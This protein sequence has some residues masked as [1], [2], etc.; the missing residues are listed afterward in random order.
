MKEKKKGKNG[1]KI[2]KR[3]KLISSFDQVL[4]ERKKNRMVKEKGVK[5]KK[6]NGRK[7]EKKTYPIGNKPM[8][9]YW[10][11]RKKKE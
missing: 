7:R 4:D 11:G 6:K 2:K 1:P 3:H 10:K 8:P 5:V 9:F